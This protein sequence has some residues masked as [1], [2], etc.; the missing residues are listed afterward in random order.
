MYMKFKASFRV[1][2]WT[3]DKYDD[4]IRMNAI[5]GHIK[6]VVTTVCVSEEDM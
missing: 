6:Q 2:M 3:V 4:A 5:S 1:E